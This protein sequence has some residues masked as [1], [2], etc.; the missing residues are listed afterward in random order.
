MAF[1]GGSGYPANGKSR[2]CS[3]PS[4]FRRCHVGR[5]ET[6]ICLN[7]KRHDSLHETAGSLD[8]AG[9]LLVSGG[10]MSGCEGRTALPP[11]E[12]TT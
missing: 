1:G 10:R 12:G 2:E 11:A 4:D 6:T 8:K 3:R 7:P 9:R 5:V